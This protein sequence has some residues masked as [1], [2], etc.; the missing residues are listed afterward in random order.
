MSTR[1]L[2][3][4][5]M[6]EGNSDELFLS[7][8]IQRQLSAL[9]AAAHGAFVVGGPCAAGCRSIART[10]ALHAEAAE[11]LGSFDLVIVHR[12][13][14]ESGK[15]E[16]LRRALPSRPDSRLVGLA[17]R[18]ETEAWALCDPE[19][20][21][22][23]PGARVEALPPRARDVEGVAD[24]KRVLGSV[25]PGADAVPVLERLGRDVRLDRLLTIPAYQS[26]LAEL[27]QALKEL[28]FL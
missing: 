27:T 11:L 26:W 16:S 6:T 23:V 9:S 1:Y 14:R 13:H 15:L 24:P 21:R 19:A 8:V 18:V 3:W 22:R 4:A 10:E 17:P 7:G 25:V 2:A 28:H 20:F 12:D 5:L